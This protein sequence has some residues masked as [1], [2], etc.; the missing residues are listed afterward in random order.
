MGFSLET[1]GIVGHQEF[2]GQ[3]QKQFLSEDKIS[4]RCLMTTMRNGYGQTKA[5]KLLSS[6]LSWALGLSL[7]AGLLFAQV[8]Q[9]VDT[10]D[11]TDE[12]PSSISEGSM[13]DMY[14]SRL[15]PALT[16]KMMSKFIVHKRGIPIHKR[17][18]IQTDACIHRSQTNGCR[19]QRI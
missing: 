17:I 11:T 9:A 7:L 6:D 10:T 1:V 15:N 3:K 2:E 13:Y 4:S 16:K 5:M 12:D 18:P 19:P 8:S 14:P